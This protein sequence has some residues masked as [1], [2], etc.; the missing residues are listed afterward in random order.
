ML[1]LS[2]AAVGQGLEIIGTVERGKCISNNT[3]SGLNGRPG[4]SESLM[5]RYQVKGRQ[6]L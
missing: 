4:Q 3:I 1:A 6:I 5:Q 2:G